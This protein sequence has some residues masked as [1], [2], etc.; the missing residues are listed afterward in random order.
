MQSA[1]VTNFKTPLPTT[2]LP[3]ISDKCTVSNGRVH[4]RPS[5][6]LLS[7]SEGPLKSKWFLL[8]INWHFWDETRFSFHFNESAIK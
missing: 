8:A 7:V 3:F 2:P 4:V 6:Y 1:N 5:S